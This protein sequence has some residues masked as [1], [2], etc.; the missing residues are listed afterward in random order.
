[1]I[2]NEVFQEIPIQ[3]P[4]EQEFIARLKRKGL[5]TEIPTLL[6]DD[7]SRTRFQRIEVKGEPLSETIIE[8]RA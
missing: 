4:R 6:P 2:P 3:D 5:I 8:D 7:D 1:M